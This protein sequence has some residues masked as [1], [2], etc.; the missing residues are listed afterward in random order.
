MTTKS[1]KDNYVASSIKIYHFEIAA[2]I[3]T[4]TLRGGL[5]EKVWG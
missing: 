4:N 2:M 3:G 1:I 5:I